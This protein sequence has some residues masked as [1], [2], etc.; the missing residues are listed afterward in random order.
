MRLSPGEEDDNHITLT[1]PLIEEFHS[2]S[3]NDLLQRAMC[4][5]A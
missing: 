2:C 4:S 1:E 3:W 5:A